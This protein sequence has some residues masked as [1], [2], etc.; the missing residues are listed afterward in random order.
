ME[1][2]PYP[3][4]VL[5]NLPKTPEEAAAR[6]AQGQ[7]RQPCQLE[8]YQ[9]RF[10]KPRHTQLQTV[11]WLADEWDVKTSSGALSAWERYFALEQDMD[12]NLAATEQMIQRGKAEGW[13]KTAEEQQAFAQCYFNQQAFRDKNPEAWLAAQKSN[14]TIKKLELEISR[15]R[16]EQEKFNR[17]LVKNFLDWQENKRALEIA[18]GSGSNAEKIELLGQAMFGED[19]K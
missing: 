9:Y 14:L 16:L 6:V 2:P 1:K 13:L 5:K 18:A 4:A 7:P 8:I 11:R 3:Q 12:Q 17:L 15:L 19:W 10:E